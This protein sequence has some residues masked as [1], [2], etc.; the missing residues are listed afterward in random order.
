M[1]IPKDP[2]IVLGDPVTRALLGR[3]SVIAE[4]AQKPVDVNI[5]I[6]ALEHAESAHG[7]D[8]GGKTG[9][10]SPDSSV[11]IAYSRLA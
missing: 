7:P 5:G 8:R 4:N 3:A 6:I 1:N 2:G 9:E 10:G 11:P